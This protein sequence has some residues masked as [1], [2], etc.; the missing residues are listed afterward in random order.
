V[1]LVWQVLADKKL[2]ELQKY[3]STPSYK[4]NSP[5][6]S[7][8]GSMKHS[9]MPTAVMSS[10]DDVELRNVALKSPLNRTLVKDE[11]YVEEVVETENGTVTVAIKGDRSK[12]AILTYHDLGLN[13]ISNFQALFNYPDM[14]EIVQSFCIFHVNAPGQEENAQILSEDFAYPSMNDLAEQ[15]NDIIN[16]FAVVRYIGIG[17]G[18][19]ANILMRHALKYPE[20]I[21]SLMVV[22]GLCSAPGWIEWGYQ[23]R[24]VNHMRN[25]G[26][27]QAVL[28]YLMWHHFGASPE[29]RAHD[30]VSVY[31]HYFNND[32]QP[33]NLAKLTEQYIWRDAIDM[34]REH[35]MDAK[36]DTKTLKIPVLNVV[37]AYSP[38]VDETVLLNGKLNPVNVN[39]LKIQDS[40]MVIEEQPG[41]IAEAF[42]LFMQGQG[43]CL[44]LRKMSVQ[45][46]QS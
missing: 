40:A 18:M 39:W 27:T 8:F 17:V 22:N 21:D 16:H 36:G 2:K 4:H 32:V 41:K 42:R 26:I 37:G 11:A 44:K 1:I 14:A 13:Y 9:I 35:N 38:F 15:V 24:N 6:F 20:R 45:G 28:D 12:P 10:G 29:E 3:Y 5:E 19:G 46:L 30:L 25:H 34:E 33:K 7:V 31:R 43:Y 23:K